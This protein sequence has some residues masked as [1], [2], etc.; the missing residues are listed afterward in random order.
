LGSTTTLKTFTMYTQQQTPKALAFGIYE[1]V[2]DT[3]GGRVNLEA[4]CKLRARSYVE[5]WDKKRLPAITVGGVFTSRKASSLVQPS[6]FVQLDLD[7]KDNAVND[8]A[9]VREDIAAFYQQTGQTAF[10]SV[11]ASGNGVFALVFEPTLFDT[12][13]R[14]GVEAHNRAHANFGRAIAEDVETLRGYRCDWSVASRPNGLRFIS[15]DQRPAF[16][17]WFGDKPAAPIIE[18]VTESTNAQ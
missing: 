8:W 9:T 16:V 6:G 3:I 12:F 2:T 15:A 17:N 11:S 7:A 5:G 1:G 13:S 10:V 4:F 14:Q 18:L